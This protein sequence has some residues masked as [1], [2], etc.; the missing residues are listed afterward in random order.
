VF[1]GENFSREDALESGWDGGGKVVERVR[2]KIF[3]D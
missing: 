2:K 3:L 1:A